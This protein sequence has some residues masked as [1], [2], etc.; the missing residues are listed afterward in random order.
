MKATSGGGHGYGGGDNGGK[1]R[2][3][4]AKAQKQKAD[5]IEART[6]DLPSDAVPV[7]G[8]D[9]WATSPPTSS[10]SKGPTK[11]PVWEGDEWGSS[12]ESPV[13]KGDNW[14]S[15]G[16]ECLPFMLETCCNR[17]GFDSDDDQKMICDELGC[18]LDNCSAS[19][20]PVGNEFIAARQDD[21]RSPCPAINTLANHGFINRDGRDVIVE[22]L[23]QA[24]EDI[25]RVSATTL[26]NAP[27]A[28]AIAL[29]LTETKNGTVVLTIDQLF[30]NKVSV[31][32][33]NPNRNL[34]EAQEH[35]S[36]F[37]RVDSD[38]L[39]DR[40]PS[41]SL[42]HDFFEANDG[43]TLDVEEV[44]EYQRM[45]VKDSCDRHVNDNPRTTRPYTAGHRNGIAIQGAL[46]FVL[47]QAQRGHDRVSSN[48]QMIVRDEELPDDY[49]P[50][51]NEILTFAD[52]CDSDDL[53]DAFR[54]NVDKAICDFCPSDDK[55]PC[56]DLDEIPTIKHPL[57]GEC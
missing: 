33:L 14:G 20:P 24:L 17:A 15:G 57:N 39:G 38:L 54:S 25:Y 30:Q 45:R 10:P 5:N 44:M 47:G 49:D 41:A 37:F 2:R 53:R 23:A 48:L 26:T 21:I 11:S 36:S 50:D 4:R 28:S 13:W 12:K 3:P 35:D 27:I 22:D 29:N 43:L 18:S 52:G 8:G 51:E 31:D 55:F 40:F 9:D 7:W 6:Y 46:L 42:I 16:S 1:N 32:A 56:E 34:G 19:F